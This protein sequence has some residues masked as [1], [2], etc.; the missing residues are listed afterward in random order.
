MKVTLVSRSHAGEQIPPRTKKNSGQIITVNG[1]QLMMPSPEY[2]KWETG[3]ARAAMYDRTAPAITFEVNCAAL[4]Y[5][6]RNVGDAVGYYQ[7]IADCLE[8]LGVVR[9]DRLIVSW[10]G[11]RMLKDALNPRV[12]LELTPVTGAQFDLGFDVPA[13]KKQ[14]RRHP[15]RI[16]DQKGESIHGIHKEGCSPQG[17]NGRQG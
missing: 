12:E 11:T 13:S 2:R 14:G 16:P 1:R 15:S 6:D 3:C 9:N 5:R 7:A 8:A 10:D 17:E 4:I